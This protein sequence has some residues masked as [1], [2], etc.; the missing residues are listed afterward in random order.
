[1][2]NPERCPRCGAPLP[3]CVC[4]RLV[5]HTTR[6]RVLVL[7]HPQEARSPIG[8]APLLVASLPNATLRAGLSWAS[9]GAAL[10]D[11]KADPARWGVLWRGSPPR[12]LSEQEEHT[13]ALVLDRQG[14]RL[15]PTTLQGIVVLDGTWSQGKTLWWRNP[16]LLKLSRV[17]LWPDQPSIYGKLRKEPRREA[18]ST[19]ESVAEALVLTGEPA[20]VREDLKRTFRTFVQ[21]ARDGAL[22]AAAAAP[23]A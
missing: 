19:L 3:W 6:A 23:E 4:D 18:L 5:P 11:D 15:Q 9:L 1:M 8:S 2:S 22:P 14:H 20:Q 12:P 10:G 21:R 16:W 17:M 7:Q 13:P